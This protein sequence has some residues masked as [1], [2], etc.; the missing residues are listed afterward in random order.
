[1]KNFYYSL[2]KFLAISICIFIANSIFADELIYI[3]LETPEDV[4]TFSENP[5]LNL[6]HYCDFFVICSVEDITD[7]NNYNY[8]VIDANAWNN[9]EYVLINVNNDQKNYIDN[10]DG[11]GKIIYNNQYFV[12]VK[13]DKDTDIVYPKV[14]FNGIV[15]LTE[16]DIVT[17]YNPTNTKAD[18]YTTY[19]D[20]NINNLLNEVNKDSLQYY[21]Q[22]LEDYG[23]RYCAS[24]QSVQAQ[25]WI[26]DHFER[27]GY[28]VQLQK[29]NNFPSKNVIAYKKGTKYPDEYVVCGSHLD[30]Y[31]RND[32]FYA[33]GA[34]DNATGTAGMME[35]ARLL[36]DYDFERSII[37]CTFTAEKLGLYGSKV[38]ASSCRNQNLNILGYFNIDMSGYLKPGNQI[39]TSVVFPNSATTLYNYYKFNVNQYVPNLYV[40]RGYLYGADSDHTP[41]NN[42]GYMGLYP[43]ENANASSPYIHTTND[44]IGPSVNNFDQVK[45]FTQA[46]MANVMSLAKLAEDNTLDFVKS[47]EDIGDQVVSNTNGIAGNKHTNNNWDVTVNRDDAN[48]SWTLSGATS[49]SGN[50]TLNGVTF[51]LGKTIVKWVATDENNTI[52]CSYEVT[53]NDNEAP[54][55]VCPEGELTRN[56]DEGMDYYTIVGDEFDATAT[57]NNPSNLEIT[58]NLNNKNSLNGVQLPIGSTTI[59]WTA[60]DGINNAQCTVEILINDIESPTLEVSCENIGDQ[61]ITIDAPNEYYTNIGNGWDIIA[62]DNHEIDNLIWTLT[63][64]T[65]NTGTET[66]DNVNFNVG[67]TYVKWLVEDQSGNSIECEFIVTVNVNEDTNALT[68]ECV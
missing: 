20:E 49:A 18:Y 67:V 54:I 16:E 27:L 45:M 11:N 28:E 46:C 40:E 10:Y 36:K 23:T 6:K 32:P 62:S 24:N 17:V 42:N 19:Y 12:I 59:V 4:Y 66:L 7:V 14:N 35:I 43:F 48:V 60:T 2:L 56:N 65:E 5:K 25:N 61:N 64:A 13:I 58:N 44:R 50:N 53:V 22:H 52:D 8:S 38:F 34:D 30:S 47:C 33:P 26:K 39:Q 9:Y 41:F 31:N 3:E 55:I 51:N 1:M 21:V 68:I 15:R 29:V 57:D 37:I 63:G